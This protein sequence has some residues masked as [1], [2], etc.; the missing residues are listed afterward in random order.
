MAG[1]G[2]S[3]SGHD[4]HDDQA[5]RGPAPIAGG[6]RPCTATYRQLYSGDLSFMSWLDR[7]IR[8]RGMTRTMIRR[9][10]DPLRLSE[11]ADLVQATYRQVW[12]L[13][14]ALVIVATR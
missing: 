5:A 4:T 12:R 7:E 8:S 3:Q 11:V 1:P 9:P 6:G 2:D 14:S 13:D 10:E